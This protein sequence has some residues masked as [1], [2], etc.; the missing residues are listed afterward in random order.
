MSAAIAVSRGLMWIYPD[1]RDDLH[2][3]IQLYRQPGYHMCKRY[4]DKRQ[5]TLFLRKKI[6]Q[7]PT[8]TIAQSD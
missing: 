5:A 1:S 3:A 2:A 7:S 6:G 4:N 8:R